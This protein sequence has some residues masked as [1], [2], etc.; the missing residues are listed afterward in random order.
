MT[1]KLGSVSFEEDGHL[2]IGE[3]VWNGREVTYSG[4]FTSASTWQSLRD[5][6]DDAYQNTV[7]KRVVGSSPVGI[8]LTSDGHLTQTMTSTYSKVRA[9]RYL[10]LSFSSTMRG[11]QPNVYPFSIKL[12]W[13]GT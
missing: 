13:L 3:A 6:F 4:V 10:L 8:D 2:V 12:F 11:G 1:C 9:G 5:M 7:I